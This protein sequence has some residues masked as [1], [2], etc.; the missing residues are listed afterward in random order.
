MITTAGVARNAAGAY[1]IGKR[2]PS[3]NLDSCW[4]FP[5]GKAG[6][7]ENAE[8]ALKRE[9]GEEFGIDISVGKLLCTGKFVNQS[10]VYTLKA[11]SITLLGTPECREHVELA[12]KTIEEI[13]KLPFTPSDGIIV[14]AISGPEEY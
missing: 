13:Q 4:E 10:D 12:W 3:E 7:D 14:D 2:R 8:E 9:F 1:F 5:G 6:P 11:Y